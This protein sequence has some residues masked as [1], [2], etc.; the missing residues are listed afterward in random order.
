LSAGEGNLVTTSRPN[1]QLIQPVIQQVPGPHSPGAKW[2]KWPKQE[3]GHTPL[4]RDDVKI[5]WRF[6]TTSHGTVPRHKGN[7]KNKKGL[8]HS[9]VRFVLRTG[10]IT[11]LECRHI[12]RACHYYTTSSIY[13]QI[14]TLKGL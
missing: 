13:F 2:A 6:S 12:Y 8:D 4:S 5:V 3:A 11:V 9:H 14:K 10:S 7:Y 1:L